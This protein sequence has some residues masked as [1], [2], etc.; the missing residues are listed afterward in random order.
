MGCHVE[1]LA[2]ATA[3]KALAVPP[4]NDVN[5]VSAE[6][7]LRRRG[8]MAGPCRVAH[9]RH[10]SSMKQEWNYA[11]SWRRALST[12]WRIASHLGPGL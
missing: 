10:S 7:L 3:T 6:A 11:F 2:R 9:L 8:A 4:V 12:M 5:Y 1:A